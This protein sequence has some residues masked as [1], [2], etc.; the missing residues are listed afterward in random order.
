[1]S[2]GMLLGFLKKPVAEKLN[3]KELEAEAKMNRAEWMSEGAAIIGLVLVAFGFWWGDALS[4]ALISLDIIYDGW[5]NVRQVIGDLMDESPTVIG[6]RKLE[7]LPGTV[8]TAAE[9]LPWVDRAAVRLRE[10]GHII[11]GEVYV[12]PS[13]GRSRSAADLVADAAHASDDLARLDWRLHNVVVVPVASLE[14]VS[15]PVT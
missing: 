13:D 10:Q 4:A 9:A 15:P 6:K 12:I 11:T 2:I 3:D 5:E 1:M 14:G 7:P 8:Q